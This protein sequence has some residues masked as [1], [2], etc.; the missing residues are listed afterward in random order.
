MKQ[1]EAGELLLQYFPGGRWKGSLGREAKRRMS[2]G[3]L[4]GQR[5]ALEQLQRVP[6][7]TLQE[8][9]R[10]HSYDKTCP[11]GHLYSNSA[12]QPGFLIYIQIF[13]SSSQHERKQNKQN[14]MV[15]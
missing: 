8:R 11:L 9:H 4:S 5:A 13:F 12:A 3:D 7:L 15:T 10:S 14:T 1:G 6:A 2:P